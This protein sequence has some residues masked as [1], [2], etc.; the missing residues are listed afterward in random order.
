MKL[1]MLTTMMATTTTPAL[2]L[3]TMNLASINDI[4][5]AYP[6]LTPEEQQ[7]LLNIRK[8][9]EELLQEIY[10]LKEELSDVN[11]EIKAMD[12]EEGAKMKSLQMGKKK[13]NMDPKKGVEYLISHD[14]IKETPEDVAAFLYKGEGLNKTMIGDY[15][16]ERN[17]FN[18]AVLKAFVELHDFTDLIVVKSFRTILAFKVLLHCVDSSIMT[19]PQFLGLAYSFIIPTTVN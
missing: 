1:L 9:K 19:G 18:E 5:Q 10:Q 6:D 2:S 14:L 3:I 11:T 15:L 17:D 12:T 16:G 13:F 4:S 7:V 8:R